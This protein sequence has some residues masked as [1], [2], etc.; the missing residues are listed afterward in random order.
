[1]SWGIGKTYQINRFLEKIEEDN[2]KEK[3]KSKK[4]KII[5]SSLFGLSSISDLHT[6]LFAKLNPV[7]NVVKNAVGVISPVFSLIPYAGDKVS[8]I[9]SYAIGKVD[10]K[11]QRPKNKIKQKNAKKRVIIILDDIE[12]I[13]PDFDYS[14]LLGY[15]NQ[16]YLSGLKIVCICDSTKIKNGRFDELKEKVFDR[17]YKLTKAS[18]DIIKT[19]FGKDGIYLENT[20]LYIILKSRLLRINTIDHSVM[21]LIFTEIASTMLVFIDIEFTNIANGTMCAVAIIKTIVVVPI[22]ASYE[23]PV[24]I[25]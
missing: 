21:A 23:I 14:S 16:S 2:K 6:E 22:K 3:D 7:A 13:R 8:S 1:M 9:V 20:A 11:I 18:E 24:R 19:Y 12:R 15:I 5:Y 4:T 17:Y 10:E 25:V